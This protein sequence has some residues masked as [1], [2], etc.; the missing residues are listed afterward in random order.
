M[1]LYVHSSYSL[2]ML[3]NHLCFY[4]KAKNILDS[5][6]QINTKYNGSF[7]DHVLFEISQLNNYIHM[8]QFIWNIISSRYVHYYFTCRNRQGVLLASF[9]KLTIWEQLINLIYKHPTDNKMTQNVNY[10][11]IYF[12]KKWVIFYVSVSMI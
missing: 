1:V 4:H 12:R 11:M 6:T 10:M 8:N 7:Y 2:L 5:D 3:L 9:E